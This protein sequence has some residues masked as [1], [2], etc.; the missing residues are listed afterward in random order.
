MPRSD[1]FEREVHDT[2]SDLV[3]GLTCLQRLADKLG[4]S[5]EGAQ[6]RG[7]ISLLRA[8]VDRHFDTLGSLYFE[9]MI[10]HR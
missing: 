10:G 1:A 6:I 9:E 5:D 8:N 2:Y 4:D 3:E 7:A